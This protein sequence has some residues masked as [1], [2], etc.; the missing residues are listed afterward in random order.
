MVKRKHLIWSPQLG[1]AYDC[2]LYLAMR[3]DFDRLVLEEVESGL[4]YS[5]I[6]EDFDRLAQRIDRGH[7]VQF[8]LPLK[9][10]R[11]ERRE[12]SQIPLFAAGAPT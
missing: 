12:G 4:T 3:R 11:A 9:H 7:G 2:E 5:I 6:A 1:V 8:Y 10:F